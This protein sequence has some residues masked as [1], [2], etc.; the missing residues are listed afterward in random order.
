MEG[1][2]VFQ[3]KRTGIVWFDEIVQ[4]DEII[5]EASA[6]IDLV[7]LD[8]RLNELRQIHGFSIPKP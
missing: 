1:I 8:K 6:R 5:Q 4:N 3:V 7:A 2:C